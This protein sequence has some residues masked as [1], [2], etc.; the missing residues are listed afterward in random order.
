MKPKGRSLWRVPPKDSLPPTSRRGRLRPLPPG[1]LPRR[2]R[3]PDENGV[4]RTHQMD[5]FYGDFRAVADVS[6]S[7]ETNKISALIG[8]SGCGKSTVLRS[9]NRMNDL[10]PSARVDGE[11]WYHG[12]NIYRARSVDPVEVR[13]RIGMVFQ[14]PN[15]FPKSIFDNIGLGC[16]DQR[17]QGIEVRSGR[18]RAKAHSPGRPVGG[19]QGQAQ[20]QRSLPLGRPATAPL[21]RPRHRHPARR[22]LDGRAVLGARPDRYASHRGA[23]AGAQGGILHHHRH[24]QHATGRPGVGQDGVLQRGARLRRASAPAI[25]SNT[26]R[27]SSSSPIPPRS[28]LRT[29]SRDGSDDRVAGSLPRRAG[30]AR[31]RPRPHGRTRRKDDRRFDRGARA[32]RCRGGRTQ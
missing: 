16:Q 20:R 9:L 23:H 10:I 14:K 26:A 17:I 18:P 1:S 3:L 4:I 21:H 7:F 30:A 6:L 2:R 27:P 12:E 15:P 24:P 29:T 28:R 22:R 8:P 31:T 25:S 19:G 11:V 5:V 32:V 13:R